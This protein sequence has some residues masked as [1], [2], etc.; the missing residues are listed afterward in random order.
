MER[1]EG[2]DL[3]HFYCEKTVAKMNGKSG[4]KNGAVVWSN[5]GAN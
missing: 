4:G 2:I 3:A 1:P 5:A